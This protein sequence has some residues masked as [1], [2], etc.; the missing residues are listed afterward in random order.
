MSGFR[1]II[2][3]LNNEHVYFISGGLVCETFCVLCG[4][5]VIILSPKVL[6]LQLVL[7]S[8]TK[9]MGKTAIWTTLCFYLLSPLH[10][11]SSHEHSDIRRCQNGGGNAAMLFLSYYY[12]AL[13]GKELL[14]P[15]NDEC[16]SL[17]KLLCIY[18]FAILSY[19][20]TVNQCLTIFFFQKLCVIGK[21]SII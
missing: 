4:I 14:E 8:V 7:Q 12:L 20:T 13:V 17:V 5:I 18:I 1:N 11:P 16:C 9:V 19:F 3:L 6:I 15:H 2:K 10:F 21:I